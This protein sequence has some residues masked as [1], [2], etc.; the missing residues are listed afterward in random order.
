MTLHS[1]EPCDLES[2]HHRLGH[3]SRVD[4]N[5]SRGVRLHQ[6][7]DAIDVMVEYLLDGGRGEPCSG[8]Q[9]IHVYL[10]GPR[11]LGYRDSL[12]VHVALTRV[13]CDEELGHGVKWLHRRADADS[14]DLRRHYDVHEGERKRKVGAALGRDEG[15]H[16]VDNHPS[17]ILKNRSEPLRCKRQAQRLGR[18]DEDVGRAPEHPLPLLLRSVAGPQTHLDVLGSAR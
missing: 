15:V 7:L 4:E 13:T 14:L 10:T 11:N 9:Y 12:R 18:R 6:L 2:L 8:K 1:L 16:L 3:V 5:Q 17:Q